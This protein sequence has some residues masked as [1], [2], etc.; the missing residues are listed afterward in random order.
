MFTEPLTRHDHILITSPNK[1]ATTYQVLSLFIFQ[2]VSKFAK[3]YAQ[4]KHKQEISL[5]KIN[6]VRGTGI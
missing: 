4:N 1:D 3:I 5:K 6:G 2:V